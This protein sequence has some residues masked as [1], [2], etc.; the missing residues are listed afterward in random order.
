MKFTPP[1]S[2]RR[3]KVINLTPLVDIVML[4]IVFFMTTAQFA[5]IMETEMELPVQAGE[6]ETSVEEAK[7]IINVTREGSYVIGGT[8]AS[9]DTVARK[10]SYELSEARHR[11]EAP[12]ITVRAD[13]RAGTKA[14]NSLVQRL[15][16]MGV[17][18]TSIGVEVQR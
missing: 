18:T 6:E 4:L 9:L 3:L 5:K 1:I 16:E 8:T 2:R 13:R 14:L 10:V 15:S 11:S 17:E 12:Q 7:L